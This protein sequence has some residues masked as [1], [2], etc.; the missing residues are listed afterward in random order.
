MILKI[1]LTL[2]V[3]TAFALFV[4]KI[5]KETSESGVGGDIAIAIVVLFSLSL[6]LTPVMALSLI[7]GF[8]E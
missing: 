4:G 3:L 6:L 5:Q 1:T 7:W 8:S 2:Y